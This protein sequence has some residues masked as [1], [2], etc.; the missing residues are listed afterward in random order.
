MTM[1]K[2]QT[3]TLELDQRDL[4]TLAR[5]F[6]LGQSA[7]PLTSMA[8]TELAEKVSFAVARRMGGEAVTET[9]DEAL[10]AA[11]AAG[12]PPEVIEQ[13]GELRERFT[14]ATADEPEPITEAEIEATDVDAELSELLGGEGDAA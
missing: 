7:D 1:R 6:D 9:M 11:E 2:E 5:L 8:T 4:A 12:A 13:I 10:A 3:L 14:M